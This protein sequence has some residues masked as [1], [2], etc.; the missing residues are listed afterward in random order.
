MRPSVK[1]RTASR[2]SRDPILRL[3]RQLK[4]LAHPG[5]LRLLAE[6]L[7]HDHCVGE[8]QARV[9]LSQPQVSQSLKL[10]K[11]AGLVTCRREKR[12]VCYSLTPGPVVRALRILLQGVSSHVQHR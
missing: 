5:R 1:R 3:S 7:E 2:P 12:R 11:E 9:G 8:M 6:L 4:S 10:L